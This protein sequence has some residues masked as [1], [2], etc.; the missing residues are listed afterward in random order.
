MALPIVSWYNESNTAQLTSWNIGTV[1]AGSSSSPF[2]VLIWNNRGGD[3]EVSD[4]Q[5]CTITTKDASGGNTGEIITDKWITVKVDS[6]EESTFTQ[7]GGDVTH[8]IR[9]NKSTINANGTFTPGVAPH[10][11][12]DGSIDI[13][14]VINSGELEGANQSLGNVVQCTLVAQIPSTATAGT[15]NFLTRVAYQYV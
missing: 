3:I 6:L 14:G 1:D 11:S 9:T 4:M 7:I 8:P 15:V 2:T 10:S 12:A 5:N 13:L